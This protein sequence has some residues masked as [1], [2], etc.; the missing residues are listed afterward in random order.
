MASIFIVFCLASATV[1][2]SEY[3][4]ELDDA[5]EDYV[6]FGSMSG[7]MSGTSWSI[8]EKV[9]IPQGAVNPSGWHMFRGKA[10]ED[11]TGDI[12]IKL[13]DGAQTPNVKAWLYDYGWDSLTM[14][15]G[16]KGI[17]KRGNVVHHPHHLRFHCQ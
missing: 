1:S 8:I 17:Y 5:D 6:D 9:R 2:A 7:F 12:A 11:K 4:V 15:N 3:F 13:R 16:D 14:D 10:W